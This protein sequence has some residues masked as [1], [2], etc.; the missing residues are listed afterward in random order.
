MNIRVVPP[1]SGNLTCK[2]N[3]RTYTGVANTAQDVPDFDAAL[4]E[5]NGW[6]VVAEGGVGTTAQRPVLHK[7]T[8][9]AVYH[10]TTLGYN[11]VWDG[12]RW[13]NPASGATV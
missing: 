11:V 9:R 12:S 7:V 4:L 6:T 1:S 5:A 8:R 3:G 10:D 2:V 13:F